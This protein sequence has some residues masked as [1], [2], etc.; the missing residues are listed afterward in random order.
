M[1]AQLEVDRY[2]ALLRA[3]L[4]PMTLGEREEIALEIGTHIRDSVEQGAS[5]EATL[6]RLGPAEELAAQYRDGLL[7]RRAGRSISPL[8][9][10]TGALRLATKGISGL[11]V[12]FCGLFGYVMGGGFVLTGLMKPIF[13]ANTGVWFNDGQFASSGTL[14]PPP[15]PP[16]H[17][18]LGIWYL[19]IA[20]TIGSLT[21]L[22]TTLVIR[23]SL[24]SSERL[25]LRLERLSHSGRA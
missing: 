18:V 19:P 6:A 17:E 21:L 11:V 22:A 16:A 13:P 20:L 23:A 1:N 5:V 2:L 3:Q 25:Q 8:L 9:L 7:I 12:F 14:F 15:G 4:G 24:R 10:L